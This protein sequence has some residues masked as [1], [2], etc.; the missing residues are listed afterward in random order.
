LRSGRPIG[1]L[2]RSVLDP[3]R[4]LSILG[5]DSYRRSLYVPAKCHA[6]GIGQPR[7][8]AIIKGM[9]GKNMASMSKAAK[10]CLISNSIGLV[11]YAAA[12]WSILAGAPDGKIDADDGPSLI[13]FGLTALPFLLACTLINIIVLVRAVRHVFVGRGWGL[14][15]TWTI[16]VVTWVI[17]YFYVRS[18]FSA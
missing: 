17:V 11:C 2:G 7:I 15:A 6:R 3:K 1:N 4:T 5:A 16:V 9:Q 13:S 10:Y 18:Q 8:P 12:C 14:L